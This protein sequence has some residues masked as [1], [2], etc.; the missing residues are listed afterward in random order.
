MSAYADAGTPIF[1]K[2]GGTLEHRRG[3]AAGVAAYAVWGA[4]PLFWNAIKQ[5][6]PFEI[7]SWRVLWALLLLMLAVAARR[8]GAVLRHA[9]AHRKTLA[10]AVVSGA[11][12]TFN[13]A[14]FIWAVTHGRI[15]EVSLGY[16]I[17]PLISVALGVV[18]L[19]EE[20]SRAARVAVMIAGFG[21]AVMALADGQFPWI[22]L[23][24]AATFAIYGLLKKQAEAAPP[25]EG[26]LL[27]VGTAVIP[28]GGYLALL[29]AHNQSVAAAS[30]EPWSLLPFTGVITIVPLLLFGVAAQRIPLSTV[31]ML[32]YLAP[33]IQLAL[34]VGL[35]QEE[36]SASGLF[37][38]ASVWVALGI[39]TADSLRATRSSESA[40]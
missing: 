34:G 13:W 21:V 5:I 12:I 24:L 18:V 28:L 11:L 20:L 10:L 17:N 15:V 1:Q 29:I 30:L 22:S 4:S 16:Y 19:R 33:T 38:F 6:P 23:S 8:R 39:F 40:R 9:I 32:Q 31:G 2:Q 27:E 35:Y 26:L 37:G 7:L 36:V 14:L 25:V 3:I